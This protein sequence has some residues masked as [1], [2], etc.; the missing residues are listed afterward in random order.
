M[1]SQTVNSAPVE[2]VGGTQERG[3]WSK[4]I[5]EIAVDDRLTR[6]VTL[7]DGST[8]DVEVH[9]TDIQ[10][11]LRDNGDETDGYTVSFQYD[12]PTGGA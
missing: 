7:E 11:I 10:Q 4:D 5:E 12:D 1:T 8:Q 2:H 3:P 9:I 6:P